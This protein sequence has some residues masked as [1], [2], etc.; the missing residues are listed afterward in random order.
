MTSSFNKGEN[1]PHQKY[2]NVASL[3]ILNQILELELDKMI[4]KPGD[5]KQVA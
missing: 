2:D 5:I 3:K 4:R 1:I